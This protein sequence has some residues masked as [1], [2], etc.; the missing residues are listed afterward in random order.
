MSESDT[1]PSGMGHAAEAE[2]PHHALEPAEP[3]ADP[4]VED[5]DAYALAAED[6]EGLAP[7]EGAPS[8]EGASEGGR[9][10]LDVVF[11]EPGA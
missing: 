9:D 3:R 1:T 6:G 10:G 8:A 4:A 7:R 11:R 5:S 2:P